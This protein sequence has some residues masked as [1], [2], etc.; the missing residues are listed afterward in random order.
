MEA[1]AALGRATGPSES[2]QGGSSLIPLV[3][4]IIVSCWD[5]AGRRWLLELGCPA[6]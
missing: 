5:T 4:I 3:E 2:Q 6:G 1:S